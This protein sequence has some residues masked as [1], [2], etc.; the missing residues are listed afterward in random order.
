[1]GAIVPLDRC[2]DEKYIKADSEAAWSDVYIIGTPTRIMLM[3]KQL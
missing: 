2:A 3:L 1:L